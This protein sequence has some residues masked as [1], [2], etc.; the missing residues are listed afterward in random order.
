MAMWRLA[1]RVQFFAVFFVLLTATAFGDAPPAELYKQAAGP[2][3]VESKRMELPRSEGKP[4]QIRVTW[5][6]DEKPCAIVVFSHGALGSRDAYDPL[7]RHWASHGYICIQPTHGDSLSLMS[8]EQRRRLG[9]IERAVQNPQVTQHWRTRP[10]DVSFV[11]DSLDRIEEETPTLK[12]RLNRDRIVSAG[13]SFGAHTAMLVGGASAKPAI[14]RRMTLTDTRVRAIVAISPQGVGGVF[15][16]DSYR[17]IRVPAFMVTGTNDESPGRDDRG[18]AW[19]TKAFELAPPESTYLLFIEG[20]HHNFGGISGARNFPSAGASNPDHVKHVCSA[21][22]AFLDAVLKDEDA[23]KAYLD[24]NEVETRSQ[25]AARV[26]RR[27][28]EVKQSEE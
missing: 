20:A 14:G 19:R 5:P 16:E 25:G 28:Q 6:V 9:T 13:H 10:A 11:I 26:Q 12:G 27:A 3:A 24:G 22:L 21:T 18:A 4:L 2:F 7:I 17:S 23:A 15:D 8:D 1:Q